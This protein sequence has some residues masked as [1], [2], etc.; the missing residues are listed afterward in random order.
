M[1]KKKKAVEINRNKYQ[2]IRKMDHNSL[3]DYLN[4]IYEMGM[5]AGMKKNLTPTFRGSE[6]LA[7]IAQIRGIGKEKAQQIRLAMMAAGAVIDGG[8]A[9]RC[10]ELHK[11]LGKTSQYIKLLQENPGIDTICWVDS[12]IVADD[13]YMRWQGSLGTAY[14]Q[15]YTFE[16]TSSWRDAKELVC[17]DDTESL[18]E[19]LYTVKGY[20]E[21]AVEEYISNIPWKRAIFLDIN[22]PN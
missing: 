14:I 21:A 22:T 6:A 3:E 8:D 10:I 4:E 15:E 16:H 7:A 17:K 18:E 1:A 19:Y 11:K 13:G 12:E 2:D 20:N 9:E 5:A